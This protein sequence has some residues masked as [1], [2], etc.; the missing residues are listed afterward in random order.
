MIEQ[1]IQT[2][3][4]LLGGR[5]FMLATRAQLHYGIN[6]KQQ[7]Y[8]RGVLPSSL[9]TKHGINNFII[10][11]DSIYYDLYQITLLQQHNTKFQIIKTFDNV[12]PEKLLEIFELETGIY[13]NLTKLI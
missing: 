6:N 9:N 11:Y 4:G 7:V 13:C 2:I 1:I 3:L 10:T 5:Q 12:A 8:L